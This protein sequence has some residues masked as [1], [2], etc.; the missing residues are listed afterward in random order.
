MVDPRDSADAPQWVPPG[1]FHSPVPSLAEV[2]RRA[3]ALFDTPRPELPGIDLR[4]EQQV[5][6]FRELEPLYRDDLFA[7]APSPDARY[8]CANEYFGFGDAFFLHALLRR[9]RPRRIVEVGS[10]WSSA[11]MLDTL[12]RHPELSCALTFVEPHTER[13]RSL[14]R[15]SDEQRVRIHECVVQDVDPRIFAELEDGDFLFVDSSHVAKTGSDVNLLV[16]E[17]LPTLRPGVLVH[18]HDVPYPFE[19]PRAWVAEG[20][21]WNEAYLMR[22]FLAF[23]RG[24]EIALHPSYLWTLD[25]D[26]AR[27]AVPRC[28]E[29][30]S[31]SLWLRRR[32][33]G[34]PR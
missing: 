30:G 21:A 24:F 28:V 14:L 3:A 20:R 8:G 9:V 17:V 27:A 5:A 10:G 31:S 4:T 18:V 29:S 25:R 23:N 11:V 22:A 6:L 7:E 19:Y 34:T 15:P 26:A 2:E 32:E 1:H 13:L 33:D 16:L 12:D